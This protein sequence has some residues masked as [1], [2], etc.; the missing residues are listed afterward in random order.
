MTGMPL[1]YGRMADMASE[2]CYLIDDF[3][4]FGRDRQW[5]PQMTKLLPRLHV[6]VIAMKEPGGFSLAYHFPDDDLRCELYMRL[7]SIIGEDVFFWPAGDSSQ[8]KYRLCD[9]LADD[10]TDMYFDLKN[11]L[12]VI[13]YDPQ[14]AATSWLSS[15]YLHWSKHLLDAEYWLH[16][17]DSDIRPLPV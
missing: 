3:G 11:G 6:A 2:F 15:F 1:Q 10:L 13:D 7:H 16:A 9:R 5:L 17:V 12:D 4:G 8:V 14:Q